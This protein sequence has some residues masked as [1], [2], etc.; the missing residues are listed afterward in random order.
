MQSEEVVS[1]QSVRNNKQYF[2]YFT[3][4]FRTSRKPYGIFFLWM[5]F[6]CL[7]AREPL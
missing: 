3:H 1:L 5:G 7:K 2:D 4:I 6:N